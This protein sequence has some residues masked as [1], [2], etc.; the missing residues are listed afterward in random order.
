MTF[1]ASTVVRGGCSARAKLVLSPP[2]GNGIATGGG[3]WRLTSLLSMRRPRV[4]LRGSQSDLGEAAPAA[5]TTTPR[6]GR[7]RRRPQR[8]GDPVPDPQCPG[9]RRRVYGVAQEVVAD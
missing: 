9:R 2:T 7:G 3:S 4:P 5:P 1:S 6:V 8:V